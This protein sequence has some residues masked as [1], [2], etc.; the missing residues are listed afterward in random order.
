[1]ARTTY[2]TDICR[3]CG[4]PVST[5]GLATSSHNRKHVREGLMA[6]RLLPATRK[7]GSTFPERR[8][9]DITPAGQEIARQQR[10]LRA[11]LIAELKEKQ[12]MLPTLEA[13]DA[14]WLE[15]YVRIEDLK[16]ELGYL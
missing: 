3:L 8:I 5:N 16:L 1:M 10:E 9:F 12:Q 15:V 14:K 2:P 7:N 6:E 13:D 4:K 11:P